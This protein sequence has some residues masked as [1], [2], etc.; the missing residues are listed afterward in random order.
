MTAEHVSEIVGKHAG[1]RG[2]LIAILQN[3]QV[4]YGYLPAEALK[5]RRDPDRPAAGG[6]LWRGHFLSFVQPEAARQASLF[7]VPGHGLP[8]A[9]RTGDRP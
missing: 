6:R 3:I 1:S 9:R 7:G 8:C 4:R 5:A 2:G